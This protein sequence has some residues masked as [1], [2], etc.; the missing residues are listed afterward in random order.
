MVLVVWAASFGVDESGAPI[1]SDRNDKED[2]QVADQVIDP[3]KSSHSPSSHHGSPDDLPQG[4]GKRRR[5]NFS[6][7]LQEILELI[8]FHGIMRRPTLDGVRVL[9]LVVPLMEGMNL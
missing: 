8:D 9:L 4:G 3:R 1:E 7:M 6:L 5:E 2:F